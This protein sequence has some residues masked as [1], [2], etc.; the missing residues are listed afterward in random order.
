MRL[1]KHKNGTE[2][3]PGKR[4]LFWKPSQQAP[5][6]PVLTGCSQGDGK[7][8]GFGP[9]SGNGGSERGLNSVRRLI[10]IGRAVGRVEAVACQAWTWR[11]KD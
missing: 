2:T 5:L 7:H 9:R 8:L 6:N 10:D 11:A 4:S 1:V 3:D